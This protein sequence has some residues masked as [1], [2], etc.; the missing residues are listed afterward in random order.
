MNLSDMLSYA[1]IS[2]L[3]SIAKQYGCECNG[4][5]KH[6][7]IQAILVNVQ[8]K[9][10]ITQSI[11][12]LQLEELRFLNFLLFENLKAY[13]LEDLLALLQQCRFDINVQEKTIEAAAVAASG[14]QRTKR[15]KKIDEQVVPEPREMIARFKSQGWLF[16]GHSGHERYM[17]HVPSDFKLRYRQH[18]LAIMQR[19]IDYCESPAT[20]IDESGKLVQDM[21]M[22]LD[23]IQKHEPNAAADGVI[24]RRA[25]LQLNEAS[26]IKEELPGKGAWKFGY[27]KGFGE[28]PERLTLIYDYLWS[29]RLI[30]LDEDRIK[31]KE[32]DL[33]SESDA[34]EMKA[35]IVHWMKRYRTPIPNIRA[36]VYW[37]IMLSSS[38]CSLASIE[39]VLLPYIKPY[40][41]DSASD[42]LHKRLV[43]PLKHFGMLQTAE[44]TEAGV[45]LQASSFGKRMLQE[46]YP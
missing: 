1:D 40:Y 36:L 34:E 27:G 6:E 28:L 11:D 19:Q 45:M 15:R 12:R 5:S 35:M 46:L 7:L 29:K 32:P 21:K 44:H 41:F 22:M 39:R 43:K 30:H 24:H 38:W 37:L 3:S 9:E 2:Q 26:S 16:N 33:L 20:A 42:V 4:H 14:K 23:Y 18:L 31:L 17:F 13:S 10:V 8:R 25:V